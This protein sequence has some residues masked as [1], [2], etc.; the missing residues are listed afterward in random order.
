[1]SR[2]QSIASS[3]D[4][5]KMLNFLLDNFSLL[6]FMGLGAMIKLGFYSRDRVHERTLYLLI[7]SSL[8]INTKAISHDHGN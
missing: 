7:W 4:F 3:Y 1:M 6:R 5:L 2:S 8:L